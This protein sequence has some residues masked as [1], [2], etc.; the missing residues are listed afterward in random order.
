MTLSAYCRIQFRQDGLGGKLGA[1]KGKWQGGAP[2]G[3]I[4][5]A[6]GAWCL[7]DGLIFGLFFFLGGT[8]KKTQKISQVSQHTEYASF[9]NRPL[10]MG[11]LSLVQKVPKIIW[12]FCGVEGPT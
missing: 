7:P 3:W 2:M 1:G 9:T 4:F 11:F 12:Y 10:V 8:R 5:A 6:G